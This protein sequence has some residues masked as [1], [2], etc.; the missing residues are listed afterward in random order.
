MNLNYII[1]LVALVFATQLSIA[2]NK[3]SGQ[4]KDAKTN[5]TL[6]GATVYI[7]DLKSGVSTNNNGDFEIE[8]IKTG[9]YLI[10]ISLVGYNNYVQKIYLTKDTE[11]SIALNPSVSELNEVVITAVTRSTELKRSPVIIKAIDKN[12]LHQNSATNLIDALKNVPGVNQISTGVAIAKPIIRGLGYNRVIALYNGIR[13]E[14][15][16]WGDEHGIE[17]DEYD[18]DRIEIVKGPGSLMY[19]SDGIAGVLNFLSPKAPHLGEIK[20]QLLTNH[21]SNNNLIGY[22]F[23]NAGNK[24]GVQWLGRFS[25]KYAGN[26]ENKYDGKVYNSGFKE[27]DGSLFLGIN[28]NWGHSHFNF[29]TYNT[30][31][32]LVEGERDSTGKFIVALADGT[33]QTATDSDLKGYKIGFPHQEINHFRVSS[34]HYFILNKG[35]VNVDFAFQNNQRKEFGDVAN[36]KDMALYFYLNTFNYNVRYNFAEKNGW[37]TSIGLGGMHQNNTNK[38]LEFLIPAYNLLDAGAFLFTQKTFNKNLTVSGGLRFDNRV[39]NVKELRLDSLGV[40]TTSQDATSNLKFNAFKQ[41]YSGISGSLGLSYLI[42][43]TSTLKFNA[44]RGFRAP[45]IAELASNGRHEGAFRYEIGNQNLKSEISHQFDVAYFLNSEHITLEVT[46]FTNF[47]SNYIYFE[48][49]KDAL[50]NDIIPDPSDPVP[51]FKF[52]QSNAT[53]LGGELYLDIHPHPL[54]WLHIENSF[55]FV[56]ATQG[57]QSDS[58]KYLPFIPAPKYRG[59]LKAQFKKTGDALTNTYIK[60]GIDHYFKQDKVFSAYGTETQTPSYTLLSAGIGGNIKAFK[61]K[62][63]MSV[64][65]SAENLAHVSY[66][67][68]LSRLK[69]APENLATGRVG[70]YNMGRNIS[71]K[72][73][74]NL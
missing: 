38:G 52:V 4:V 54:D 1:T 19:G 15:Q 17:I 37:E 60:F 20:S 55:S 56:Q 30:A 40:P 28:K 69:Y 14:G 8:N 31:L 51:A 11:L 44:S 43:T 62:D 65:I 22:S 29:S 2:Q 63:A 67:S 35:T 34:N 7:S 74:F 66:Q 32:N 41:N 64:Y 72:L 73:I 18:I 13:Q 70:V 25:N 21:Q 61:K 39:M 47:I 58:T 3:I 9:N 26:Y 5:E 68:H 53:L 59:E 42:N 33:E 46:P 10:E 16:Q 36:P 23:S 71:L 27:Y 57:N 12:S 50:G 45:T 6:T 48:K 49:M 24:N